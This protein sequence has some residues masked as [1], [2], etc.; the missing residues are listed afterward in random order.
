MK[1]GVKL[2]VVITIMNLIGTGILVTTSLMFSRKQIRTMALNNAHTISKESGRQIQI[3]FEIYLDAARTIAQIMSDFEYIPLPERR[4]S[5]NHMLQSVASQNSEVLAVWAGF[6]P[7]S[8]DG[9]DAEYANTAGSDNTGRFLSYYERSGSSPALGTLEGY[10]TQDFYTIP[11]R[12]GMEAV[13]EPYYYVIKGKKLLI[14]SLTVPVKH[15]GKAIGVVGIDLDLM[16][17]QSINE[18]IKP[19]QDG[20]SAVFSN[21]GIVVAHDD[22]RRMG[23]LM[24]ESEG[25]MAGEYL[26]ELIDAVKNGQDYTFKVHSPFITEKMIT[27]ATPVSIGNSVTPWSVA[28]G[29]RENTVLAPVHRMTVVFIIIGILILLMMSVTTFI[30]ARTITSP[31]KQTIKTLENIEGDLTRIIPVTTDDEIGDMSAIFNQT[32]DSMKRLVQII[33]DKSYVLTNTGT[34][35]VADMTETAS[36]VNEITANIQSMKVQI[37]AQT[38]YIT[39]SNVSMEII[40]RTIEDLNTHILDQA[41]GVSSSSSAIEEMLANINSVVKTLMQNSKNVIALTEASEVGKTSVQI[42]SQDIQQIA[43][44][45]EGLLE[46]NAVMEQIAAQTNLL[47]M[48]AAIEAAHAGEVGKGFA[49]VAGE[50][51]KLAESSGE[52]AKTTAVMLKNIKIAIDTISQSAQDVLDRFNVIDRCIQV[53]SNQEE[54]IRGAMEEQETG[55][56]HILESIRLLKDLTDL[57]KQGSSEMSSQGREIIGKT[58]QLDKISLEIENGMQEMSGGA[59]RILEAVNRVNNISLDNKHNIQELSEE[60][61]KFKVD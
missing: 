1:I 60:V 22:T 32:F 29:M 31:I 36:A 45:S 38:S 8:I 40:L 51:R 21:S 53:V 5:F 12:T 3:W 15:K 52:Q 26:D 61:A 10:E 24:R 55:S 59:D 19:F 6:E 35:L 27:I 58:S 34:A 49:V 14:T 4:S 13:I 16:A 28:I 23:K 42:V 43:R 17:I 30:I 25:D 18:K 47:S 54:H 46:I 33:R 11:M 37:S 48:N 56:K 57:V 39:E 44:D 50:I 41:S 20:S 2:I 7:D 9:L